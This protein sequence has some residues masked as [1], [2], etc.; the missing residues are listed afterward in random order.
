MHL[1]LQV[2]RLGYGV[3][4]LPIVAFLSIARVDQLIFGCEK[5]PKIRLFGNSSI[6]GCPTCL[7]LQGYG[8]RTMQRHKMLTCCPQILQV[9]RS[10]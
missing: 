10:V 5:T 9:T 8:A 4:M 2:K 6:S 1:G 3:L 7:C